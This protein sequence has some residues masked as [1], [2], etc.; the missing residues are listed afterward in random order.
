MTFRDGAV[1]GVLRHK[2]DGIAAYHTRGGTSGTESGPMPFLLLGV[3]GLLR[4]LEKL[5]LQARR[6]LVGLDRP[7][8]VSESGSPR[9]HVELTE[10]FRGWSAV[11]C[12]V[13]G[14]LGV[15]PNTC[16]DTVR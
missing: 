14:K 12:I 10:F 13:V 16:I 3:Q 2:D 9:L 1:R 8:R 6:H 11:A 15:P 4:A 7:D 5:F